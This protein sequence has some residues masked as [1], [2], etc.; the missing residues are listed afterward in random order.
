MPSPLPFF[1][2]PPSPKP[3]GV[4]LVH[5]FTATPNMMRWLGDS[6]SARGHPCL[7]VRL[8]GH[9]TTPEEMNHTGWE[10]WLASVE[11]GYHFLAGVTEKVVVVGHSTGG[12]LSL[13]LSTLHPME[14]VVGISALHRLP[15]NPFPAFL[16]KLPVQ[17]QIRTLAWMGRLQPFRKKGP[18]HW[19]DWDAQKQYIAYR[20]FPVRASAELW[21]MLVYIESRLSAVQVPALLIHSRDDQFITPDQAE[22]LYAH[23]GTAKK[24]LMWVERSGHNVPMDAERTRVFAKVGDFIAA[25][26]DE[27]Q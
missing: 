22:H 27:Y 3:L 10:A 2:L 1:L 13:L 16:R 26:G 6:L 24:E 4:L 5:G 8:A 25:L 21:R 18:P 7:G 12:A 17:T 11:D 23:L 14:G 20:K 15:V 19:Y 9:G